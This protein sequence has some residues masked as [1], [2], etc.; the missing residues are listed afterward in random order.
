MSGNHLNFVNQYSKENY[1]S[2]IENPS[3]LNFFDANEKYV[4][5]HLLWLGRK[6][7]DMEN[8]NNITINLLCTTCFLSENL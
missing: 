8:N 5:I 2:D 7:N 6:T 3:G 1:W 4:N